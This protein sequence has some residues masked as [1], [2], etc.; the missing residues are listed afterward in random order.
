ML[1]HFLHALGRNAL[2]AK[3][4]LEKGRDVLASLGTAE[5]NQKEGVERGQN[6]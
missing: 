3:D 2:A 4:I 6:G 5:R 1:G